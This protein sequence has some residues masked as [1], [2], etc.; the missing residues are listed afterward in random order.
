MME[1]VPNAWWKA[2]GRARGHPGESS[3]RT[4]RER[5]CSGDPARILLRRHRNTPQLAAFSATV[6]YLPHIR[7][8]YCRFMSSASCTENGQHF[9]F[10]TGLSQ[11]AKSTSVNPAPTARMSNAAAWRYIRLRRRRTVF[12]KKMS[13]CTKNGDV[14]LFPTSLTPGSRHALVPMQLSLFDS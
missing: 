13:T 8:D 7:S 11:S 12:V 2:F 5:R 1:L 6:L 14:Y 9:Y 10:I 4:G 3:G